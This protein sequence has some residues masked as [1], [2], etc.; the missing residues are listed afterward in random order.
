MSKFVQIATAVAFDPRDNSAIDRLWALDADG[1]VWEF[2][3]DVGVWEE[4]SSD[5]AVLNHEDD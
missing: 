4:M 2:N 3:W 5:R 1:G